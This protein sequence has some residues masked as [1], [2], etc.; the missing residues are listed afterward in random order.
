MMEK[1]ERVE[2]GLNRSVKGGVLNRCMDGLL[3]VMVCNG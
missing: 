3:D 2:F 1:R